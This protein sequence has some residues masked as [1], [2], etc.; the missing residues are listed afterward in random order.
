MI[1]VVLLMRLAQRGQISKSHALRQSPSNDL[2][3]SQNENV[4]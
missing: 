2:L 4:E 3:T 1:V